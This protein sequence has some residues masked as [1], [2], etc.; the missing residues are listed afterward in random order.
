MTLFEMLQGDS[1][2]LLR[3]LAANSVDVCLCS[4]PY[5]GQ[6]YYGDIGP[7]QIGLETSYWDYID[8]LTAIFSEV[9]RVLKPTG[10]LWIVIGDTQNGEK[11]GNTNS[12]KEHGST[13]T[14][15]Q[16]QGFEKINS[17][18]CK[19][20]QKDVPRGGLL[21][22]PA[23]LAMEMERLD[24]WVHR[25]TNIWYKPNA[26]PESVGNR[27]GRSYEQVLFFSKRHTGY[28]F[29]RPDEPMKT[30]RK[31]L[32]SKALFAFGGRRDRV[33][34]YGNKAYSGRAWMVGEGR[35]PEERAN[36]TTRKARNVWPIS[37]NSSSRNNENDRQITK[38]HFA[39]YPVKLCELI[40]RASGLKVGGTVLD[41]FAGTGTTGVAALKLG[42]RFTGIELSAEYCELANKRL[43]AYSLPSSSPSLLQWIDMDGL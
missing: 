17:Q 20:L 28:S 25:D 10:T 6:R 32:A 31:I 24:G 3:D 26:F 37:T 43:S 40:L 5:W 39:S 38:G 16:K 22:I 14:G 4:P 23:K 41:P 9:K 35:S 42:C 7:D 33:A 27:F 30:P 18:I 15:S 13:T 19:R 29:I 12:N 21:K 34:G 2:T 36:K 11:R 8:K 1:L